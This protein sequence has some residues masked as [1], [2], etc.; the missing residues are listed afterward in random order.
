[1][2]DFETWARDNLG[3]AYGLEREDGSYINPVTRWA[4]KAWLAALSQKAEPGW[5]PIETAPMDATAVLVMR[6]IWPG[7]DSGRAEECNGHNT[8]VAAWWAAEGDGSGAWV[9]YMDAVCDPNCPI[10]PTHWMPL[11]ATPKATP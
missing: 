6:D 10:E 11:P 8:Y 9:C 7:T 2:R 5:Q 1:M 3:Q 4:F